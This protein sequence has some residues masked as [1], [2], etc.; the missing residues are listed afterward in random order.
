[1]AIATLIQPILDPVKISDLRPTQMTVGMREV[2]RKA[3]AWRERPH[4]EAG[5][6]LGE[7]MIPAVIGPEKRPWIVDHHHLALALH[8]EGVEMVLI[9]ILARLDHLPKKRFFAFMDAHNWLHP[10][11]EEGRPCPWKDIPHH[12]GGL[13]DDPYR[14][15]AGDVREAGGFAKTQTP[16]SEFLWADYFRDHIRRKALDS[17]YPEA[18]AHALILARERDAQHLP[19]W[20]GQSPIR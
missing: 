14:S 1:M 9:S 16:Y 8:L 11:D 10:Y 20:A 18:V 5:R 3:R 19:G 13:I 15:L 12:V 7:R 17:E 6:Y 4:D 2:E